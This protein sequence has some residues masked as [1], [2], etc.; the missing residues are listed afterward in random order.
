MVASDAKLY[1]VEVQAACT[2]VN[3]GA[4]NVIGSFCQR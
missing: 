1:L 3:I 4:V 2:Q